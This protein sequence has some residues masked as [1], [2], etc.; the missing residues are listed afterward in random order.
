MCVRC[1]CRHLRWLTPVQVK[2]ARRAAI[3]PE[4]LQR[5]TD[6]IQDAFASAQRMSIWEGLLLGNSDWNMYVT[7]IFIL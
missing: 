3:K 7:R 2:A 1:P 4:K 5:A 6:T